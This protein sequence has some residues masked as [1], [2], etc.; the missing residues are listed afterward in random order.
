MALDYEYLMANTIATMPRRSYGTTIA[1]KLLV[2]KYLRIFYFI[3][4][5]LSVESYAKRFNVYILQFKVSQ[6]RAELIDMQSP[7]RDNGFNKIIGIAV[8]NEMFDGLVAV[9]G[10][11]KMFEQ[12][13][14]KLISDYI[15]CGAGMIVVY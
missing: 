15:D 4:I 10:R 3:I 9:K 11:E 6:G 5:F 7:L 8:C 2:L 14:R 13:M 1:C 12:S